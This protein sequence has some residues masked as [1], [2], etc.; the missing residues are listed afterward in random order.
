M[1]TLFPDYNS[2]MGMYN[3]LNH[4]Y[5]TNNTISL[6]NKIHRLYDVYKK[7]D[8]PEISPN[9]SLIVN[10][11]GSIIKSE[12][13]YRPNYMLSSNKIFIP[14]NGINKYNAWGFIPELA[15]AY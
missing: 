6:N 13:K 11:L 5:T 10:Y 14:N 4:G 7:S 12:N 2:R 1:K 15:H 8:K 3:V 9:K